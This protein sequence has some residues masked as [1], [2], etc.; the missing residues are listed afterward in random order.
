M[1]VAIRS[2][3][4]LRQGNMRQVRVDVLV[5]GMVDVTKTLLNFP[6]CE[7]LGFTVPG[8]PQRVSSKH[9]AKGLEAIIA[10]RLSYLAERYG[11]LPPNHFGARKQRSCEQALDVVVKRIL[12]AWGKTVCCRLVH[13]MCKAR[14]MGFIRLF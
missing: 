13:S 10:T 5:E 7:P 12:E 1:N 8:K 11:L 2:A 4:E 6:R 14:S 3:G 9:F